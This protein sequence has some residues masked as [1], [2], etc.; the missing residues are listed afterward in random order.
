MKALNEKFNNQRGF[1]LMDLVIVIGILPLL[2]AALFSITQAAGNSLRTQ[3]VVQVLNHDGM[4]ML[5]SIT[6]E[7][8]QSNPIATDGQLAIT[9]GSPYD[10]VRF[11]VPVDWDGDGDVTGSAEDV[12]EWGATA[13]CNTT[14]GVAPCAVA[15]TNWAKWQNYWVQYRVVGTT[16]YR[17]VLD[18]TLALVSGYQFTIAK[19]VNSFAVTQSGN[20]ITVT[21]SFTEQDQVGER[22]QARS[23]SQSYVLTTQTM[24]RNVVDAE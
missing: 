9:D 22:G 21:V 6:R 16:L 10:S 14:P 18:T 12:F 23:F 11:R 7:L 13:S 24:M 20:L 8:S 19:N 4:Q 15:P 17:E 3:N 2:F 1:T 5:R